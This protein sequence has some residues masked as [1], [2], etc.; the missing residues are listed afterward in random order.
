MITVNTEQ[1]LLAIAEA[2]KKIAS[3][4]GEAELRA[5]GFAGAEVFRDEA[6]RNVSRSE[7]AAG[8]GPAKQSG[9]LHDSIIV[10]RLE[11]ESGPTRQAYIA[12]VRKGNYNG[13]DAFYWRFVE[14]GH[15]FV[16]KRQKGT[17]ESITRRRKEAKL[18]K[19]EF[20]SSSVPAHPFMRPA[21]ESKKQEAVEAMKAKLAEKIKEKLGQT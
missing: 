8:E 16:R 13:A 19:L 6:K 9:T 17:K 21:Y 4:I 20:G 15:L 3:A 1:F 5:V 12:T 7:S 11:E 14:S 2:T 18:M 10:K